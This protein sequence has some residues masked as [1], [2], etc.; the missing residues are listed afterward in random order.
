LHN[1]C[2]KGVGNKIQLP[3]EVMIVAGLVLFVYELNLESPKYIKKGFV[4][5]AHILGK[6]IKGG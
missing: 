5:R 2:R 4:I 6:R 1:D 3:Q